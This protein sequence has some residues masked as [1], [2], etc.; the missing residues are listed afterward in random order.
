VTSV[1]EANKE[2]YIRSRDDFAFTLT[3]SGGNPL[4]VIAT[5]YYSKRVEEL[6]PT[7]LGNGRYSYLIRRITEPWTVDILNE[8]ASG[9]GNDLSF[10]AASRVWSYAGTLYIESS[11]ACRADIYT[12]SGALTRRLDIAPGQTR[13]PL[14]RGLYIIELNGVHHKVAVK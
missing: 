11:T 13:L 6:P 7:A 5:G 9:V 12:V 14:E 10:A 2:H 1:P 8:L 3:F 4:K